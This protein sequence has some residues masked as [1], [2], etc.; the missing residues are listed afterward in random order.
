MLVPTLPESRFLILD[1][2]DMASLVSI[3][4]VA[5]RWGGTGPEPLVVPAWWR[6]D[7]D[8]AM[9]LVHGAVERR[10]AAYGLGVLR[11][12]L[13]VEPADPRGSFPEL[14]ELLLAATRLAARHGCESVLFPVRA[15]DL[16]AEVTVATVAREIDRA[17]LVGRLAALDAEDS[18]AR[19]VI[20]PL[21]DFDD[22]QL[23]DLARDL[24]V[25]SDACWWSGAN[26]DPTAAD[27]ARRWQGVGAMPAGPIAT[28]GPRLTRTA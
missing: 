12:E 17:V 2:A 9:P 14:S 24:S 18:A 1:D 19:S 21:V 22:E 23:L 8:A 3:A 4:L 20:T 27:A 11:D 28:P 26:S 16:D 10:A 7:A 15:A 25:P 13:V 5:E 6:A